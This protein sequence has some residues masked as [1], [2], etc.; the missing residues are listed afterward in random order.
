MGHPLSAGWTELRDT[1]EMAE[2]SVSIAADPSAKRRNKIPGAIVTSKLRY[3]WLELFGDVSNR[4]MLGTLE[5]W[6]TICISLFALWL[7]IYVHYLA[8]Y[9]YLQ[10]IPT[11]VYG[12]NGNALDV[13][14]KYSS[15]SISNSNEIALV[16]LGPI[17]LMVVFSAVM[18]FASLFYRFS[19]YLPLVLSKFFAAFGMA[20]V[21]DPVLTFL[22]DL[23][24]HN[25]D[26]E[27]VNS[28]CIEDYT[29]N[30][31]DCF[32][33][34]FIKL[35]NRMERLEGSGITGGI[36]TIIVYIATTI[37]SA[38]LL[39]HY[40]VYIHRDGNIL[41]L[42]RRINA[43]EEEFFLPHDFEVSSKELAQICK[44]VK[45]W[46]GPSGFT[47]ILTVEDDLEPDPSDPYHQRKCKRYIITEKDPQ[48]NET[49]F[50]QFLMDTASGV[51]L[52]IFD[53]D[54]LKAA[55]QAV[56]AKTV[57]DATKISSEGAGG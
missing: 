25:Y 24:Y 54:L 35:W 6:T 52:E 36:I 44:K 55:Q 12:Y 53:I 21:F 2:Y 46:R 39:Y 29:S 26:C 45:T 18:F 8:Q 38:Q 56:I 14:F 22:V 15:E 50:R 20:C 30:A 19:D 4:Y 49:T 33:G 9:L 28:A 40:L 5:F 27:S 3:M 17:S 41:D 48:G 7:R 31:C 42:W 37:V 51:I 16:A 10:S 13:I 57:V 23:L 47:R 32:E 43:P 34:D 1:R 11:P